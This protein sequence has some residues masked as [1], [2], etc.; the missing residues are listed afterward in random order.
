M[1]RHIASGLEIGLPG[2]ISAGYLVGKDSRSPNIRHIGGQIVVLG[3]GRQIN[4]QMIMFRSLK[5]SPDHPFL[6]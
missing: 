3:V 1:L 6:Q 4:L 5:G 2:R